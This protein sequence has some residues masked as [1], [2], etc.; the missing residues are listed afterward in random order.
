MKPIAAAVLVAGLM[1]TLP[2]HA[3]LD[4][5][6]KSNCLTCHQVDKKMVGP[7]FQDIAKK[8][9]GDKNAAKTL[10]GKVKSGGK[11]IWGPVAMPPSAN[12]KDADIETLVKWV[13]AGAK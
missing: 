4:L 13:L 7:S 8:Y 5:A 1:T 12:V 6:K 2:A 11:G 10:A 9:A 3:N